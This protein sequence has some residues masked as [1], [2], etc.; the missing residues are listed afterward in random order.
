M[1]RIGFTILDVAACRQLLDNRAVGRVGYIAEGR[2][3]IV[4]V[5]YLVHNNH[6]V[7]RSDP[8]QKMLHIPLHHVCFEVDGR[9]DDHVWS[10]VVQG[11]A[12]DLT[13]AIGP[14]YQALRE[15]TLA[16]HAPIENAHWV[17]I[18]MSEVTGRRLPALPTATQPQT[19]ATPA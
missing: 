3:T 10:V 7:F 19:G 17:A 14:D 16:S 18:D 5:D 15:L 1:S 4:P 8:G 11:F 6:I 9:D 13:T 12:R 2:P